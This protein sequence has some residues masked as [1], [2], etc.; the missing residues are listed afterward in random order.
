MPCCSSLAS[1]CC[2]SGWKAPRAYFEI[3]AP[4]TPPHYV[5][6]WE[7]NPITPSCVSLSFSPA[8]EPFWLLLLQLYNISVLCFSFH[9]TCISSRSSSRHRYTCI[10]FGFILFRSSVCLLACSEQDSEPGARLTCRIL[11][12]LF[13]TPQLNPCQSDGSK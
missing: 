2:T 12:H 13:K 6:I 8:S 3:A 11:L 9:L 4:I 1:A 7:W 10:E 5:F